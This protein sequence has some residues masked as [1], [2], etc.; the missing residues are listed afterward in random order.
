MIQITTAVTPLL[1]NFSGEKNKYFSNAQQ[2]YYKNNFLHTLQSHL[3]Y[4]LSEITGTVT[5]GN[6]S[7]ILSAL[8][9]THTVK[10]TSI[11]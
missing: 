6:C 9:K 2:T 8:I 1:P 7:T 4:L 11:E 5:Y 3:Y 10:Y